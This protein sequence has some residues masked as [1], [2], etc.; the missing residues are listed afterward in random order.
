MIKD[1]TLVSSVQVQIPA[2]AISMAKRS[3]S[4]ADFEQFLTVKL[5]AIVYMSEGLKISGWMTLPDRGEKKLPAIVFNRGGS[6]QRAA[7]TAVG[8]MAFIGLYSAWGYVGVASNYRGVGGSE[9]S[10]ESW[11]EK[12]VVDAL[13]LVPLLDSMPEVDSERLGVVGGSRGGLVTYL[14]LSKTSRFRAAICFGAPASIHIEKPS[15]YI[16]RTMAKHLPTNTVEQLEAEKRSVELWAST[17]PRSTPLLVLHGTGDRRVPPTH[18]LRLG[19]VL[20]K[21]EFPYKLVMY[22]NADHVLA[23]RR[24]ESNAEMRWWMDHYVLN[25]SS[26]PKTGP[27]GA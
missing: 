9:G 12:D 14:M 16:R 4:S 7:L 6:G 22:D 10:E 3:L 5:Y 18:S 15:A 25:K 27:H 21:L 24:T 26:P 23:G 8:A 2:S 17:L 19:F 20:Q 11:G 13:N 1:G